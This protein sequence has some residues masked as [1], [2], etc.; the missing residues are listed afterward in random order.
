MPGALINLAVEGTTDEAVGKKLLDYVDAKP[1]LVCGKQGKP[2]LESKIHSFNEAA[3]HSPWFV[4][5]D[6]DQD[7][8]CAPDLRQEW[9][10]NPAPLLCFRI[11]V[12]A[13]EA[14]LLADAEAIAAFLR[15][16]RNKVPANPEG[17]LDPKAEMVS[18]ARKSRR[19]AIRKDMV[20]PPSSGRKVGP[21]YSS[22]LTEFA[23]T[24]WRA[25]VAMAQ[26]PSLRRAIDCL[27]K[28]VR[29]ATA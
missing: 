17:L 4:I 26:A 11:A 9:L 20:P 14:W 2:F 6:L 25:E 5:V 27:R 23:S 21:A 3:R 12:R 22:R 28:L 15:I 1:N 10:P 29:Q 7:F 8:H 18:L 13:V 24:E 19:R 16:A